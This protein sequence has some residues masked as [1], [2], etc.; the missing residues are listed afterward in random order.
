MRNIVVYK[1]QYKCTVFDFNWLKTYLLISYRKNSDL[2]NIVELSAK[3]TCS[4]RIQ[5]HGNTKSYMYDKLINEILR[6][7]KDDLKH[8]QGGTHLFINTF[9]E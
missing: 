5:N 1:E 8:V 4:M 9:N 7:Y 6:N 2:H 3:V